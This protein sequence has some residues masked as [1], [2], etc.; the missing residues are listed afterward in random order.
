PLCIP[1]STPFD[2]LVTISHSGFANAAR[3][4]HPQ[5]GRSA[6][7]PRV[8]FP[9]RRKSPKARQEA[10]CPLDASPSKKLAPC[11]SAPA[12]LHTGLVSAPVADRFAAL[13]RCVN[14][15]FCPSPPTSRKNFFSFRTRG[16]ADF[17]FLTCRHK[18]VQKPGR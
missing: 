11:H 6:P 7:P 13:W 15:A 16:T 17:D 12:A 1:Y 3:L 4:Q 9:S 14:R 8:T 18:T 10:C 2:F 5:G